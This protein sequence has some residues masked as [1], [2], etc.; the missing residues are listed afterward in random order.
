V[1]ATID[2]DVSNDEL[3]ARLAAAGFAGVELRQTAP[4]LEDVFV[5][6]TEEA[7]EANP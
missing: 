5:T 7:T 4:S 6:L 2:R 1:H 3:A